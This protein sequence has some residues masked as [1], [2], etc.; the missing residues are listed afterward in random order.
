VIR[1]H[2]NRHRRRIAVFYVPDVV[3]IDER[4]Q[5]LRGIRLYNGDGATIQR[6]LIRR[7]DQRL[8]GHAPIRT[9]L[10]WCRKRSVPA[11]IITH[12]GGEIV[13]GDAWRISARI[14]DL[15]R[16]MGVPVRIAYDGMEDESEIQSRKQFL[17]HIGTTH[18][19]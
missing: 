5:A 6:P 9:Q 14:G 12:C 11:V 10:G 18:V 3:C 19:A 7:Q 17:R 16:R 8:I 15:A 13:T 2:K 1:H 4:R